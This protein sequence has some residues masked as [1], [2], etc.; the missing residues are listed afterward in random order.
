MDRLTERY[1]AEFKPEWRLQFEEPAPLSTKI[2]LLT[3]WGSAVIG[4][5]YEEG[6]WEAWCPLPKLSLEQ[7]EKLDEWRKKGV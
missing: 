7:H 6:K 2:L 3:P 1:V 5:W 4:S